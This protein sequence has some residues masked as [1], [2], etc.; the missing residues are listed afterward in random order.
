M[1]I[2]AN[3]LVA[4]LNERL[5]AE[6]KPAVTPEQLQAVTQSVT[7]TALREGRVDKEVLVA[8]IAQQTA[9]SPNDARDL[10]NRVEAQITTQ[11]AT[12]ARDVKQG[13]FGA[14]IA[15]G[16]GMMWLFFGML[17]GLVAAVLGSTLGVTQAQRTAAG[18]ERK[19]VPLATSREAHS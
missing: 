4:P 7:G 5:R 19:L 2:D 10:A 1:G 14:A 15:I 13:A 12:V 11:G 17:L 3:E 9:L 18:V 16:K 8:S 6:G